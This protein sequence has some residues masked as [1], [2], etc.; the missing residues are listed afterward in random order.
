M[1]ETRET[2]P[3]PRATAA[4]RPALV[5]RHLALVFT[6]AFATLTGFFLLFSVVP[7]Y[8]VDG[9]AGGV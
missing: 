4:A 5:G 8:A 1:C 9:G 6:A 7:M 2:A 3:A